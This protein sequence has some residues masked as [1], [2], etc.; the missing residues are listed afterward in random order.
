MTVDIRN[1]AALPHYAGEHTIPGI[2]FAAAGAAMGITAWG[3][4]VL[5]F[6]PGTTG[7][8]QHDHVADGQEELYVV[9]SGTLLLSVDGAEHPMGAG[10]MVRMG[11]ETVRHF[12]TADSPAVL[13]VIGNAPG[14]AYDPNRAPGG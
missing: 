9:L 12:R 14:E 3:M 13:L 4:N 1:A 8:P 2:E 5:R 6:A 10:D 7:Y 11:P